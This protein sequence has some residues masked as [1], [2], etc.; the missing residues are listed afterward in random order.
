MLVF[1][2]PK[3]ERLKLT[4][5]KIER[6]DLSGKTLNT[7]LVLEDNDF[8]ASLKLRLDHFQTSLNMIKQ[9]QVFGIGPGRWNA[10]KSDFGSKD[11]NIMDSH[12]DLLAFSSQYG[13]IP[14]VFF[15]SCIYLT[16]LFC[17]R[18]RLKEKTNIFNK[19]SYLFLINLLM[20]FAGITNAG[21]FKHQIVAF[22]IL[23][24]VLGLKELNPKLEVMEKLG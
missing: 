21:L 15:V 12:N 4:D 7:I 9:N 22:L 23:I 24:L 10:Y 2:E 5:F 18:K 14:G 13:L 8:N 11:R 20:I 16:P 17:F 1:F 6:I 3:S 19:V